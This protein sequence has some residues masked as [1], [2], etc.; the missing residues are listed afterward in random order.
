[1]IDTIDIYNYCTHSNSINQNPTI[2]YNHK[3]DNLSIPFARTTHY[4]LKSIKKYQDLRY[5]ILDHR[6]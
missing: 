5:G 2:D 3:S 4:G 1:M 6:I